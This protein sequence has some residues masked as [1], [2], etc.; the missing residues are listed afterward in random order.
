VGALA[1]VAPTAAP[2]ATARPVTAAAIAGPSSAELRSRVA[3]Q[4]AELAQVDATIEQAE[5]STRELQAR[6]EHVDRERDVADAAL[7]AART[8]LS[9]FSV[10]AYVHGQVKE[11]DLTV[12][13]L[14]TDVGDLDTEGRRVLATTVH[15]TLVGRARDA[16]QR[17]DD[18]AAES[19]RQEAEGAELD[20]RLAGLRTQRQSLAD[21]IAAAEVDAERARQAE[22]AEAAEQ[23]RRDEEDARRAEQAAQEQVLRAATPRPTSVRSGVVPSPTVKANIVA[24]LGGEVPRVALDAYYRSAIITNGTMPGCAIDWA[25]IGAIGRVETNHGR[26]GGSVVAPD[27]ST[28]PTILGIPLDGRSGT[29]RITDTDHGELDGDPVYDRAVGPMQFIPGTWR[30]FAADGNGDGIRDPHNL[31]DAAAATGRYLCSTSGGPVSVA[32]NASRAV[33]AYN[34]SVEYNVEVLTLADHYRRTIDPSLPPPT[35]P[36]TIPPDPGNLPPPAS[37]PTDPLPPSPD[38]TPATTTTTAAPP[39]TSTTTTTAAP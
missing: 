19:T 13:L 14:T 18:L 39:S 37:P 26:F 16:T 22:E 27:G 20:V 34:R 10:S 38:P 31:Y 30:A 9:R 36:P 12:A 17:V 24:L 3:A 8:E 11:G 15:A 6:R 35:T 33:Y 1:A 4:R 29:A 5:S 25:L 28:A 23:R 32:E 2:P 7:G 21:R